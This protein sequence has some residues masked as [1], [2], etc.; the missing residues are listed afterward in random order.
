EGGKQTLTGTSNGN[1]VLWTP[2][3][4][5]SDPN[6]LTPDASPSI[7]TVYTL[8]AT[9][10]ICKATSAVTA[11]VNPAPLAN[12]GR[13][14]GICAGKDARLNGSGGVSYSWTPVIYLSDPF[15]ANPAVLQPATGSITYRLAVTDAT[16]CSSLNDDAVT[17]NVSAPA[18]LFVGNDTVI[19]INQPLQLH[20]RDINNTGFNN[21]T[22]SPTYGLNDPF[23]KDPVAKLDRDMLYTVLAQNA[24]GCSATDDIKIK[25]YEGPEIYV[26]NAFTPGDDGLNDVLIPA[27]IGMKAF[28]Y[29]SVFN[30]YGQM[31]YTTATTGVGWDGTFKSARQ[32]VGTYTWMAEAIDYRGNIIQRSGTVILIR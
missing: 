11:F 32:P 8:T 21:Y 13:D 7:T 10:G 25:V 31:V 2:A 3:A 12:A 6:I 22:W 26:P 5:L 9:T 30:R 29:F 4:G 20:G 17:V 27:V 28:H 19:A 15:I 14:T 1:S 18:K 16:G 23:A 24:F